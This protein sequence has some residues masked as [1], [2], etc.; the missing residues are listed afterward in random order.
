MQ[1]RSS[2]RCLSRVHPATRRHWLAFAVAALGIAGSGGAAFAQGT[3]GVITGRVT[4]GGTSTPLSAASVRV[5]GTQIGA[6]TGSD[7][8]YTI[9]GVTPGAIDL[10]SAASG[11]R[12][13]T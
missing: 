4:E 9:R 6:Q 2:C 11:T 5:T 3:T 8:R 12:P 10:G 13:S 1:G 7:G